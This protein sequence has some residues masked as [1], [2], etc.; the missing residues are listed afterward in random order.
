MPAPIAQTHETYL[1]TDRP[2][3]VI[4]SRSSSF[5]D[6]MPTG[7]TVAGRPFVNF[8]R[9]GDDVQFTVGETRNGKSFRTTTPR[10]HRHSIHNR[11]AQYL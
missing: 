10:S 2:G 6:A 8:P 11:R 9:W 5:Y 4:S 3:S 7:V 1:A